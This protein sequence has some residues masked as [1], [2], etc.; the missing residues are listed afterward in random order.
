MKNKTG[1][2][3]WFKNTNLRQTDIIPSASDYLPS[4]PD[5]MP[6]I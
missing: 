6:R 2:T 1:Q 4:I 5:I 3:I